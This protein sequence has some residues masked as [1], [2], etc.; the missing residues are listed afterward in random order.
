MKMSMVLAVA[1]S[2]K[3][4]FHAHGVTSQLWKQ[5]LDDSGV[6]M[7]LDDFVRQMKAMNLPNSVFVDCTS[8]DAVVGKYREILSSSISIVTPNKIA[9]AGT[10]KRY[11]ALRQA[12][13]KHNVRFLYAANVG[14][15]LPIIS[16]ID[17]L[18][19]GGDKIL[20]IEGVLSGTLSYIFNTL[21]EGMRWSDVVKEARELGYTEPDPREDLNGSDVGRKLLILVSPLVRIRRSGSGSG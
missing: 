2:A 11:Q 5:R 16:T 1:N 7:N 6:P 10:M 20:S 15:G 12:A 19:A 13:L 8:S 18:V 9:N 14:A 17:D 4:L 21:R 3:M